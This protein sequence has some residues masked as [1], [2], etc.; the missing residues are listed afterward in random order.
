MIGASRVEQIA[1]AATASGEPHNGIPYLVADNFPQ[2]GLLTAL[3]FL[4]WTAENPEGVIS[5]P[6]GKTPEY[7]IK[8]IN[9][10]AA[11]W[12]DPSLTGLRHSHGLDL[13]RFPEM[14]GLQFVQ[15]DAFFPIDPR[16]HNSF[17]HYVSHFYIDGF[18]L[19]A[20]RAQ[21]INCD[22][23]PTAESLPVKQIFPDSRVDLSLRYRDAGSAAERLQQETVLLV[24]Q[25]CADYE[26]QIRDKGG[27]GFFL[28]GIGPD[29]HIAFNVRGSDHHSTTRLTETNFET[30]AA[31]AVDLGGI[32]ISRGRLVITIGLATITYNS[33]AT[34]IIMAAGE[35]KAGIV[36]DSLERPPDIHYPATALAALKNG[37]FYLTTGA[38]SKL[39]SSVANF[40]SSGDWSVARS[41]RA[42][43]ALC[44]RLDKF[45][46][47][48]TLEDLAAD[49]WC[50]Q[51]P[52]LSDATVADT[53]QWIREKIVRGVQVEEN[54]TFY[55]T[56]PHHDDILLGYLPHIMH[57][58][59]T[60]KNRQHFTILTS[61]FTSVTNRYVMTTLTRASE[62]LA[63]GEIQMTGYPDFYDSGYDLK[64]DKD[65]HH[66]LDSIAA[67][68]E[69]GQ[70]RGLSHRII[71]SMVAIYG[72]RSTDELTAKLQEVTGY[73]R[74]SYDG[75]INPPH[76]QQLKGA[77]REFE[78]ELVWANLGVQEKDVSHLRLGFYTGDIFTEQPEVV[79]DVEPVLAE[80]KQLKPTVITLALDPE[81]SGPDTHYKVLQTIAEAVRQWQQEAD[82]SGL[83]IWG[84]RNVWYRFNV[85]SAD[86]I[87]PV[88]LGT[89]AVMQNMFL[90][91]YLSQKDASF[92]SHE[93]D[94]PFSELTQK[95]WV[96]Q[97]QELELLL[98]KDFWYQNPHPRLRAAHGAIYLREMG[99]EQFLN[100]ARTLE[101]SMEG[102]AK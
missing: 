29:G 70:R 36:R 42:V 8:W 45:G 71:R 77:I 57:L 90:S 87:I 78:E 82:L 7:F 38:A 44:R 1:F 46:H 93:L 48:L 9:H 89:M 3:R 47:H 85:A 11:E 18:G 6:T 24:D 15:I 96:E 102:Q 26:R 100:T 83:R 81:G 35:S 73:L 101:K 43:S 53:L 80:L 88:S 66:Y 51:I 58:V 60:P 17:F 98:G 28:G 5:L 41:A 21:L 94:G 52:G 62:L 84:Y 75:E 2:L 63:S 59:R 23:I 65:V 39:R 13:K 91:S 31:A 27:I 72:L 56:G 40:Y 20:G 92:P 33:D 32:E 12:D 50:R 22:D 25:W 99:V 14:N 68:N 19:D 61:G 30:Q 97:Y 86:M 16:Q 64:R 34:A 67:G 49:P 10:F 4:E 54:Q 74:G 79:R 95:I 37:R 55:H 76:I 69:A